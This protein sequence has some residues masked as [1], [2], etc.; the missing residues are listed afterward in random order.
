MNGTKW[1]LGLAVVLILSACA[2][3]DET[4]QSPPASAEKA[5]IY[6]ENP[7]ILSS[8][9]WVVILEIN[10]LKVE[11]G[12]STEVWQRFEIPDSVDIDHTRAWAVL[13]GTHKL[14]V[15]SCRAN[16]I[17]YCDNKCAKAVLRLNAIAGGLYQ[18]K[19]RVGD[20]DSTFRIVDVRSGS[21]V[22]GPAKVESHC[23]IFSSPR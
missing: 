18:I 12:F 5:V 11:S 10:R 6:S 7:E 17:P 3:T 9:T 4:H 13:P 15:G 19:A 2:S 1:V 14:L 16:Y 21:I 8:T 23:S 20:D 22:A